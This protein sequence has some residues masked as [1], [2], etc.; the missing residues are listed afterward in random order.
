[1]T[2]NTITHLS[3]TTSSH[4][5]IDDEESSN[6]TAVTQT[7]MHYLAS[8]IK[9]MSDL[10]DYLQLPK[11]LIKEAEAA[12][13][14]FRIMAPTP[15]LDRIKKGNLQDPLLLQILPVIQETYQT[16]GYVTDPLAEQKYNPQKALVHKYKSRV[17]VIAAGTCAINCR[18][19][20]RRH[21]PYGDNH[22]AKDEWQSLI[23]YIKLHPEIN[24]V[25]LS[26]GD[27]LMMKDSQLADRI[28]LLDALP[29]L[30]R[31]RIHTRLPIVIPQR[32]CD[33]MLTWINASRLKIIM[34]FHINHANEIDEAVHHAMQRLS[35]AK[36]TLLNQG[37]I[38]KNVNDNVVAQVDLSERLFEVGILPYYMFTLDP[39]QGA[40]HFDISI[41]QAQSLMGKVAAE[42]PGYLVPKL[43][44]E[45]HGKTAKTVFSPIL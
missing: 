19:C 33:D 36:V 13:H 25:I 26:G 28:L 1:M 20:F 5:T 34:V 40:A 6:S 10:A 15:Y 9:N 24:E 17:L 8:A 41:E 38:L 32:V 3:L 22:L 31:L 30:K 39:V 11:T 43:A 44:K 12:H 23:D 18:Y 14:D 16:A 21:F 29:Q 7:W 35:T 27:P 4:A 37:V 42:L 45:I 2:V